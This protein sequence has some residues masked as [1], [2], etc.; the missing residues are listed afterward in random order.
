M[1]IRYAF[2]STTSGSLAFEPDHCDIAF[3]EIVQFTNNTLSRVHVTVSGGYSRDV[4]PGETTS[5]A[6]SFVG[7]AAGPHEVS[8]TDET[9][10]TGSSADGSITVGASPSPSPSHSPHGHPSSHPPSPSPSSTGTGPQVAPT[11]PRVGGFVPKSRPPSPPAGQVPSPSLAPVPTVTP[12]PQPSAT[13]VVAGPVEPAGARR[14]GL[15]AALAALAVV[16][17]G[18][19]LVRVVLAEPISPVDDPRNVGGTA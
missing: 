11:P 15:P 17:S 18:A 3:G 16:G 7:S 5:K 2:P 14:L 19:G 13:A 4:T 9:V 1:T 12:D 6:Q 10:P 8:A